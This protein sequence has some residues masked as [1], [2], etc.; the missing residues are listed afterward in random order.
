MSLIASPLTLASRSR[1]S[2][3]TVAAAQKIPQLLKPPAV[4]APPAPSPLL[5]PRIITTTAEDR[6]PAPQPLLPPTVYTSPAFVPRTPPAAPAPVAVPRAAT[7]GP[8]PS[9]EPPVS[10]LSSIGKFAGGVVKSIPVV[11]QIAG[12]IEALTR[13]SPSP[14]VATL[15]QF[16]GVP[17]LPQFQSGVGAAVGTL[18]G[19]VASGLISRIAGG[20]MAPT[21]CGCNGA[22]G[23]DPCTQQAVTSQRAPLATFFGGCCPPGRV[24]RRVAGG[25]DICAR[26]ARMNPFNP[27]ALARADRRITTFARRAAPIMK[28]LGFAVSRTRY[29]KIKTVKRRRRARG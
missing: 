13:R 21:G 23:R 6:M 22:R 14:T 4:I 10:L 17:A 28:D 7:L 12:G 9:P 24:L 27:R 3:T 11:G 5:K 20:G 2:P 15:P 8:T 18:A 1:L 19:N 25:R 26:R 16:G 29:P